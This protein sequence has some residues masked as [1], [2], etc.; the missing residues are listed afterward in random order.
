MKR[1]K[2]VSMDKYNLGKKIDLIKAMFG[3]KKKSIK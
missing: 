1:F 2:T 3:F